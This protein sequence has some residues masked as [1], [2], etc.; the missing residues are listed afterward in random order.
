[1][2]AY[3]LI[4]KTAKTA[5]GNMREMTSWGSARVSVYWGKRYFIFLM[6]EMFDMQSDCPAEFILNSY[7]EF[8]GT[9]RARVCVK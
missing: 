3:W 5:F 8:H 2:R 6:N 4:P 7:K 1:M 9:P